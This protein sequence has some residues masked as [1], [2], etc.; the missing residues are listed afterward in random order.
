MREGEE[1]RGL[2]SALGLGDMVQGNAYGWGEG[3]CPHG[4]PQPF[5]SGPEAGSKSA[6]TGRLRS[7]RPHKSRG[8]VHFY[9]F[10]KHKRGNTE[11]D[12]ILGSGFMGAFDVSPSS[13]HNKV[14]RKP[15]SSVETR[16]RLGTSLWPP[17]GGTEPRAAVAVNCSTPG[18]PVLHDFP[19]LAQTH[20]H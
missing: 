12:D 17:P 15:S 3:G 4:D 2:P 8:L 11:K 20:V 19:Q 5:P 1:G 10:L 9:M 14:E 7:V 18:F 16:W 6:P 13:V